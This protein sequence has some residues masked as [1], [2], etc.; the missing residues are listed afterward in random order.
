MTI[1][2]RLL[3]TQLSSAIIFDRSNEALTVRA[4]VNDSNIVYFKSRANSSGSGV[5]SED[6]QFAL[7]D[8]TKVSLVFDYQ[9]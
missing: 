6:W 9:E 1:M 8:T 3:A 5:S 7:D 2:V 4:V